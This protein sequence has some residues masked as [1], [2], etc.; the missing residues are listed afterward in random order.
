[1]MNNVNILVSKYTRMVDTLK[2]FIGND[3]ENLQGNLVFFFKDEFVD[4]VARL[5]Y[6]MNGKSNYIMLTKD[7]NRYFV[8]IKNVFTKEGKIDLQLVITESENKEGIPIFKSNPFYIYCGNSIN[9]VEEAPDGYESWIEVANSKIA[10]IDEKLEQINDIDIDV[11][12]TDNVST[13]TITNKDGS[14]KSVEV[15]DGTDGEKGDKG[16][17]GE[18][19]VDGY[20]PVKGTDYWTTSD[21]QEIVTD[22]VNEIDIPTKTSDLTNDSG[23]ITNAVNDLVNYYLKND[24]YSKNEVN[25]LVNNITK[26]TI[27]IVDTLPTTGESNIIYFVAKTGS[28]NDVYDEYVFINGNPEHIG[29]TDVDLTGYATENWVNTQIANFLTESQVNTLITNALSNYSYTETDPT[30][31]SYVK[32]ITNE[33]IIGWNDNAFK[34]S[35]T[36]SKATDGTI[37]LNIKSNVPL[38]SIEGFTA[39]EDNKT[40]T[41]TLDSNTGGEV[42]VT[43]S[44]Y[45]SKVLTYEM[46]P[47]ITVSVSNQNSDGTF[48]KT[49]QAVKITLISDK[50]VKL[51]EFLND[52]KITEDKKTLTFK[53]TKSGNVTI[54]DEKENS[55]FVSYITNKIDVVSPQIYDDGAS[56]SYS[57]GVITATL[58]TTER[59]SII[60]ESWDSDAG[61]LFTKEYSEANITNNIT[62]IIAFKDLYDNITIYEILITKVNSEYNISFKK[63]NPMP[64]FTLDGTTLNITTAIEA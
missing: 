9:A 41:K 28:T 24:T 60:G 23:F 55:T 27:S 57:N 35:A 12:K 46:P 50:R 44:I 49:N 10:E 25:T 2:T 14:T 5:E 32:A 37:T 38:V 11:S 63:L 43:N 6:T 33:N 42:T 22:V 4:G 30:V 13:I 45:G 29:S 39:S 52:G 7:Y 59:S 26:V 48:S 3:G 56:V 61:V 1:M 64:I 40:L 19:G 51:P 21:K 31:P 54:Y 18:K 17:T 16:D 58:E 8:P 34:V 62:E 53:V 36:T 47:N 20:T 15:L